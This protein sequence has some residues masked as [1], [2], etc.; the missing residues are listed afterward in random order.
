MAGKPQG[1]ISLFA[2][3]YVN[4]ARAYRRWLWKRLAFLLPSL[5]ATSGVTLWLVLAVHTVPWIRVPCVATGTIL[6]ALLA[7]NAAQSIA[8]SNRHRR[9]GVMRRQLGPCRALALA[10]T[11]L[12]AVLLV[13]PALFREPPGPTALVSL[14]RRAPPPPV[15]P[16]A[17]APRPIPEEIL[18]PAETAAAA[19]PVPPTAP[20]TPRERSI[21]A[22]EPAK[23]ELTER[24]FLIPREPFVPVQEEADPRATPE[25]ARRTPFRPD[26]RLLTEPGGR[27]PAEF[28]RAHPDEAWTDEWPGPEV[29]MDACLLMGHDDGRSPAITLAF[30]LPLEQDSSLEIG[31][32]AAVLPVREPNGL[33]RGDAPNWHH[34]TLAYER[35]LSG[36][37][38]HAPFDLAVG[39]GLSMDLVEALGTTVTD[40]RRGHLAPWVSIDA[41][42]WQEGMIGLLLHAGQAVPVSV[43]GS[44]VAV[45][46]LSATVRVDVSQRLSLH[47]GYRFIYIRL[48][49]DSNFAG[50]ASKSLDDSLAGPM[51]GIDLRF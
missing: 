48:R 50:L 36:Y 25:D 31:W 38:R 44:S 21:V 43:H 28:T 10:S 49:E 29:R 30:D 13:L 32:T 24:E 51:L 34:V 27:S 22:L 1:I 41:A 33:D 5:F 17:I 8:C 20:A 39:A 42:L 26:P 45:T 46:D 2:G 4:F 37:T 16:P 19:A 15:I 40:D 9:A 18:P 35:R 47:A 3:G 6:V 23:M 7:T 11:A 12:A 14:P